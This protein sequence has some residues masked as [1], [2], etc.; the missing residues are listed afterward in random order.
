MISA[1][2][3]QASL[4]AVRTAACKSSSLSVLAGQS[5]PEVEKKV[6]ERIRPR[7]I[8]T[9]VEILKNYIEAPVEETLPF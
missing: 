1:F 7:N 5:I 6:L 9:D 8:D 2:L 3:D 4:T